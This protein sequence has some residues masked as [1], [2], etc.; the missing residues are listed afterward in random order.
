MNHKGFLSRDITV[1]D[2]IAL[3]GDIHHIFPK[4]Y[5][6]PNGY[7][8]EEYNQI[9]NYAMTQQ[10]INIKI[11]KKSPKDY[12]SVVLNQCKGATP[13]YGGIDDINT[14]RKN[15]EENCVPEDTCNMEARDY[16]LF[17]EKRRILMS[18]KIR[19]YYNSL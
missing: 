13:V 16:R 1:H 17:L 5:L 18:K 15:L 14:F 8:R 2:M 4:E 10:E 12:L 9:A 11:G 6:K 19:E 7:K 3:K